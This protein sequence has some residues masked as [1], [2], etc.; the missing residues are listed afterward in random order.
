M[1]TMCV[2]MTCSLVIVLLL[3]VLLGD[4]DSNGPLGE[5]LLL[6][7]EVDADSEVN[8]AGMVAALVPLV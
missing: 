6:G 5:D 3:P 2:A 8:D 4:D 7:L 1:A